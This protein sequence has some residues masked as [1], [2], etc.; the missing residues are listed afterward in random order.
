[1]IILFKDS[2]D[3]KI[4]IINNSEVLFHYGLS[5]IISSGRMGVLNEAL[6]LIGLAIIW[7]LDANYTLQVSYSSD[8][9]LAS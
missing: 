9:T 6:V 4:V 8:S 7:I 1:M 5:H 2:K 3:R